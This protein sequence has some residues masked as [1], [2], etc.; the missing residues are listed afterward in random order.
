MSQV[1]ITLTV[2]QR[3]PT[4]VHPAGITKPEVLFVGPDGVQRPL[5]VELTLHRCD[6][7]WALLAGAADLI[8]HAIWHTTPKGQTS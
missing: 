1:T 4:G 5:M 8:R 7:C 2:G 6:N 3:V